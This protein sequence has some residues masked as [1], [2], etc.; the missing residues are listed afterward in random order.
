MNSSG[1][2]SKKLLPVF[3]HN[4]RDIVSLALLTSKVSEFFA[5]PDRWNEFHPM[6]LFSLASSFERSENHPQAIKGYNLVLEK[7][8]NKDLF[9]ACQFRLSFVYKRCGDWKKAIDFWEGMIQDDIEPAAGA[10]EELAKYLEHREKDISRAFQLVTE[11]LK[12]L[13]TEK[14][15]N[16]RIVLSPLQSV[17]EEE[18]KE[19][20]RHRLSRLVRKM[21]KI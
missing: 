6:D 2:K 7:T 4:V 15:R 10:Y 5:D 16:S 19:V 13:E 20:W 11:A 18:L 9:R 21:Q 12:R 14:T 17:T 3:H 1:R 8:S